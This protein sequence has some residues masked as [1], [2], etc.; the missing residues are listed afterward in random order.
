MYRWQLEGHISAR[1]RAI[2]EEEGR[3]RPAE[4]YW[5]RACQ[6]IEAEVR[7]ALEGEPNYVL[8]HLGISQRPVRSWAGD[9]KKAA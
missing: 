3:I 1:S 6:E 5:D 7:A 2:W 9:D 8:P 4:Y